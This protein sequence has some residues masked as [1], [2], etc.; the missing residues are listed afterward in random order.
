MTIYFCLFYMFSMCLDV[1]VFHN[2]LYVICVSSGLGGDQRVQGK[3]DVYLQRYS[4][5]HYAKLLAA[6]IL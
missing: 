3:M 5:D 2:V 1:H 6:H 4:P